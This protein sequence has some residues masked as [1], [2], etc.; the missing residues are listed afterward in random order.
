[1]NAAQRLRIM[2]ILKNIALHNA[3]LCALEDRE[4]TYECVRIEINIVAE[5]EAIKSTQTAYLRKGRT[6]RHVSLAIADV[7]SLGLYGVFAP[8]TAAGIIGQQRN[9]AG[10][11]IDRT[12]TDINS[13][14]VVE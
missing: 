12:G 8:I 13:G 4:A 14:T 11:Q 10:H 3:Q 2:S 1:M 5:C 9:L 7:G 6:A